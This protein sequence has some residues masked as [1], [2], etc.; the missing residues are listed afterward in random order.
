MLFVDTETSGIPKD[1][2]KPYATE[3]NW[4][5][6]V[7]IAWIVFSE[8]AKEVKTQNHYIK[9]DDFTISEVSKSIHGITE[10]FLQEHGKE[11]KTVMQLLHDDLEMYQP[12]VVSHF[13]QL[14]FH[15]LG[16]GFYR[17]GLNNPVLGLP[18][19]CT[20]SH[21]KNFVLSPHQ[22]ALRL[23][24]LY[25][26]LF[27]LP[28]EHQHDALVDARATAACYFK[29]LEIGD[30]DAKTIKKQQIT[31]RRLYSLIPPRLDLRLV[32]VICSALACL[33]LLYLLIT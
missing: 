2:T 30:I 29:M 14:D 23:G 32:S 21:T 22:R 20:M 26:R 33:I 24:E 19:F 15:M 16:L 31:E 9:A 13:A 17:A 7:Q 4:P 10:E 28:L 6:I 18:T 27:A 25:Q 3:D 12:M 8:D 5:Y 11:R 1:W